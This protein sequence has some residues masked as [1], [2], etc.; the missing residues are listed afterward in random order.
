LR[1]RDVLDIKRKE[2][3]HQEPYEDNRRSRSRTR[4]PKPKANSRHLSR[5]RNHPRRRRR[6]NTPASSRDAS[7]NNRYP[8]TSRKRSATPTSLRSVSPYS[9]QRK[10]AKTGKSSR[11]SSRNS[12]RT[13]SVATYLSSPS[14]CPSPGETPR[15]SAD[16]RLF[17]LDDELLEN[18]SYGPRYSMRPRS[19]ALSYYESPERKNQKQHSRTKSVSTRGRSKSTEGAPSV[20]SSPYSDNSMTFSPTIERYWSISDPSKYSFSG[21]QVNLPNEIPSAS[22][23]APKAAPTCS[24]KSSLKDQSRQ[25]EKVLATSTKSAVA[26]K[27]QEVPGSKVRKCSMLKNIKTANTSEDSPY[28][29]PWML[30]QKTNERGQSVSIQHSSY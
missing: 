25:Q 12:S 3:L 11:S 19:P 16:Y 23:N 22:Y 21:A 5:N 24:K 6:S 20:S 18:S 13:R 30:Q 29:V 10:S 8:R 14:Y 27:I 1:P 2:R 26:S 17:D 9:K 7:P 4:R 15:Y 28:S